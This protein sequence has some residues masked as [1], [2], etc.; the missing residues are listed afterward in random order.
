MSRKER[1]FVATGRPH[2][3]VLVEL[4]Q[5]IKN[6]LYEGYRIDIRGEGRIEISGTPGKG[7]VVDTTCPSFQPRFLNSFRRFLLTTNQEGQR[8]GKQQ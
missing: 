2:I 8:D 5:P 6:L 3:K 1:V 7:S 4:D